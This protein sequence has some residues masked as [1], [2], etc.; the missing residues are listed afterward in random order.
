MRRIRI[1]EAEQRENERKREQKRL[2]Y[3]QFR[4]DYKTVCR[5][6]KYE[7]LEGTIISY[8][9]ICGHCDKLLEDESY[10]GETDSLQYSSAGT[11]AK[12][13]NL[14]LRVSPFGLQSLHGAFQTLPRLRA[15]PRCI[16]LWRTR[17]LVT[18]AGTA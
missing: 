3:T 11:L 14:R 8:L 7:L 12:R 17:P 10:I 15:T 16:L 18:E 6:H 2:N 1:Q 9:E 13:T 5:A 4:L